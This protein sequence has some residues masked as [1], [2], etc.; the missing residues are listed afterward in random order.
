[1]N[2]SMRR[3]VDLKKAGAETIHVENNDAT[4]GI[5]EMVV[6]LE[7]TVHLRQLIKEEERERGQIS[8]KVY[9]AYA[10]AVAGGAFVPVYLLSQTGFQ[11]FQILSSYWMA[12]GTSRL[13]DGSTQVSTERLLYVYILLAFLAT[14]CMLLRAITISIVGLKTAQ[15]YFMRMLQSIFRAPMSFF[16][17]T[18]SGRIL[19]RVCILLFLQLSI[20]ARIVQYIGGY[21]SFGCC[22][23]VKHI[24]LSLKTFSIGS[25][26][27]FQCNLDQISTDQS[28]VDLEIQFVMSRFVNAFLEL[29]GISSLMSTVAWRVLLL[30]VPVAVACVLLQVS[31][32][33]LLMQ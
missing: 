21:H 16:D 22:F 18:P 27:H 25:D 20:S 6:P 29:L 8:Y 26:N 28:T 19:S 1:M 17:S 9:W 10:S 30:V 7:K 31:A 15:K 32:Q 11:T 13:E 33:L 14:T 24:C 4:S 23:G 5:H 3:D 2:V 12:W